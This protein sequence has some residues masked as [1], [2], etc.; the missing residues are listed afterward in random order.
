MIS[1]IQRYKGFKS[2]AKF[3][4]CK[5]Y[6][7]FRK[8]LGLSRVAMVTDTSIYFLVGQYIEPLFK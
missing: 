4:N 5:I 6:K 2:K 3:L 1:A 7:L 8:P